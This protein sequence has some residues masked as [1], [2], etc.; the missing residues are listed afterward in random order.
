MVAELGDLQ[1]LEAIDTDPAGP[2]AHDDLGRFVDTLH[3][4]YELLAAAR[5]LAG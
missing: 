1:D 2:G 4:N 5:T 3:D